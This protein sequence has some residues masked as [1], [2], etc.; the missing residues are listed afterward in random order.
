MNRIEVR[1]Q[2]LTCTSCAL[3]TKC[4][5]PVP[6][7][8]PTPARL[9]VIGEAPGKQEDEEG[10]P[11]VGPA[12]LYLHAV[13]ESLGF[14]T[15]E[16]MFMNA[17]SCFPIDHAGRGRTPNASEIKACHGNMLAQIEVAEPKFA[18]VTGG[19]P[20]KSVRGGVKVT[21]VRGRP[22]LLGGST[23][24]LGN[25]LCMPTYHP[26]YVLRM[27]GDGTKADSSVRSDIKTLK[28]YMATED[29]VEWVKMMPDMC[30]E[31]NELAERWWDDGL[32]WCKK[33]YPGEP[34]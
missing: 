20:L 12:G 9:V 3:S 14:N 5:S 30:L 31:C 34:F 24:I 16:I 13:L 22:F 29:P 1:S 15:D 26:S 11:F 4:N 21:Q 33:H 18:L 17:V 27:G 19:V 23:R 7:K 8:G 6:F 28:A 25:V 32:A 2:V 10:K